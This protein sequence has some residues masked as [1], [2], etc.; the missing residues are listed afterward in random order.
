MPQSKCVKTDFSW[1]FLLS[2]IHS[3]HHDSFGYFDFVMRDHI[4][5]HF[6]CVSG[7]SHEVHGLGGDLTKLET[8]KRFGEI[9]TRNEFE[10][11]G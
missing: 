7:G 11:A 9:D 5:H 6:T 2:N 3:Y 1:F 10:I 4:R 8:E